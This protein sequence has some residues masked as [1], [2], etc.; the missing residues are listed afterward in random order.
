[1]LFQ[2]DRDRPAVSLTETFFQNLFCRSE[3]GLL[4]FV[5][6]FCRAFIA[7]YCDRF[8][9]NES[10]AEGGDGCGGGGAGPGA[11]GP[12]GVASRDDVEDISRAARRDWICGHGATLRTDTTGRVRMTAFMVARG[13]CKGVIDLVVATYNGIDDRQIVID[14]IGLLEDVLALYRRIARARAL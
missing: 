2:E 1:M 3:P 10:A 13:V 12:L 7:S 5:G 9:A 4:V 6:V 11:A 14:I 8:R